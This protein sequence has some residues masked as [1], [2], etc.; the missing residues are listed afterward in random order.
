MLK[1]LNNWV[2]SRAT[3]SVAHDQLEWASNVVEYVNY[4]HNSTKPKSNKGAALPGLQKEVPIFGPRFL[5]PSY[6]HAQR[7]NTAPSVLPAATYLKALNIVHPFYYPRLTKCPQCDSLDTSWEGWTTTGPREVHGVR[8]EETALG[9]QLQCRRC[10][11][12]FGG[13]NA[14]ETGSYCFA[15]TN[16]KFFERREY[17][18]IARKCL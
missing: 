16:A 2:K 3:Q 11:E 7:R 4:V 13:R 10:E 5:P 8:R 1:R 6:I 9:F 12:R 14:P 18:E 15:T 17:W